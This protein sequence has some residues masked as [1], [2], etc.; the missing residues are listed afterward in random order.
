MAGVGEVEIQLDGKTETLKSSLR[1]GLAI[2]DMG[3]ASPVWQ[4]LSSLDL[5]T[6]I[7]VV[8]IGLNRPQQ[9]VEEAVY[10]TGMIKLSEPLSLYVGYVSNG[11]KPADTPKEDAPGEG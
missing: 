4:R 3:G 6:Y 1:A 7:A 2:A 10:N 8:A 11:G 9:A 5:R